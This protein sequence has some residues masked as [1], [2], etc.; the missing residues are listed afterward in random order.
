MLPASILH[1][2]PVVPTDGKT[3]FC[4]QHGSG[5]IQPGCVGSKGPNDFYATATCWDEESQAIGPTI[6]VDRSWTIMPEGQS[7]CA[8]CD[9]RPRRSVPEL[10]RQGRN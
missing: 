7:S 10:P 2:Q 1:A 5:Q 4:L 6:T 9:R 3:C 8:P